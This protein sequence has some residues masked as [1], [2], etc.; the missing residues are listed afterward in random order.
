MNNTIK[1]IEE[2]LFKDM[3]PVLCEKTDKGEW[4]ISDP[5][6]LAKALY[7]AGLRFPLGEVELSG[8]LA[9]GY[10]HEE[11]GDKI[12][13]ATLIMAMANEVL[14]AQEEQND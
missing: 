9:R 10:C 8:A 6:T 7:S 5:G 1:R 3:E 11:C 14:K 12:L 2:E 4:I 13:D